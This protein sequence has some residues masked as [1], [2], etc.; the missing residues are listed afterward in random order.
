MPLR[1]SG[2]LRL[3]LPPIEHVEHHAAQDL[4]VARRQLTGKSVIGL[5]PAEN[6]RA[7]AWRAWPG[8]TEA[9]PRRA[10]RRD[11]SRSRD[12]RCW[13]PR[14]VGD[15]QA[16]EF[17]PLGRSVDAG[18]DA[19][20]LHGLVDDRPIAEVFDENRIGL[21]IRERCNASAAFRTP[22]GSSDNDAAHRFATRKASLTNRSTW[23]CRKR[24]APNWRIGEL[25]QILSA[26]PASWRGGGLVHSDECGG[27]IFSAIS[28]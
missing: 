11:Q 16:L 9:D 13:I 28:A 24:L 19:P 23:A 18:A 4:A 5:A 12:R 2:E 21:A 20:N 1:P 6:A 27:L 8:M 3:R 17:V 14:S 22:G 7:R 15:E 25:G 10:D 26:R